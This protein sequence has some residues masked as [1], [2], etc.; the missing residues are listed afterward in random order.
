MF[1][2]GPF[3]WEDCPVGW[4]DEGAFC[5]EEGHIKTIAKK[6]YGALKTNH[7]VPP[8]QC[9]AAWIYVMFTGRGAGKPLGC[10]LDKEYDAGLCYTPCQ[11][12]Y[13]GGEC[14]IAPIRAAYCCNPIA[15][16]HTLY[17]SVGPVCWEHCPSIRPVNGG[18]LCCEN[19]AVCTTKIRDLCAGLPIAIAKAIIAGDNATAIAKAAEDAIDAVLGFVMPICSTL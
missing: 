1:T 14:P 8:L 10:P 6:S 19:A 5:R 11:Q 18:A 2:V 12:Q 15:H 16:T 9:D 13:Y 4:V 3:C 17:F 7:H